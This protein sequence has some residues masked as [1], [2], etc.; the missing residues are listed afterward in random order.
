MTCRR[1]PRS[2]SPHNALHSPKVS[3]ALPLLYNAHQPDKT[4]QHTFSV[5]RINHIFCRARFACDLLAVKLEALEHTLHSS[6]G[7]DLRQ[8]LLHKSGM[9]KGLDYAWLHPHH[10]F[11]LI[12][13]RSNCKARQAV[14]KK[15]KSSYSCLLIICF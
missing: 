15:K 9:R 1:L 6:R 12:I 13:R 10:Y 7:A 11:A 3:R 4:Y 8:S 5:L 14:I 2:R